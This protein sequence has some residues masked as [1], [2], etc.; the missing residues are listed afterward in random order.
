VSNAAIA[1]ALNTQQLASVAPMKPDRLPNLSQSLTE[2]DLKLLVGAVL[3]K[4]DALD[5]LK[6]GLIFNTSIFLE[7]H[8]D[9]LVLPSGHSRRRTFI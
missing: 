7:H 8:S 3:A 2:L 6:D 5:G 4:C 9:F 1:E